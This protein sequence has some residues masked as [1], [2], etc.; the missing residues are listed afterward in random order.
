[1]ITNNL[2]PIQVSD[3]IG[4]NYDWLVLGY[5]YEVLKDGSPISP[6]PQQVVLKISNM[7]QNIEY[8]I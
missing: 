5:L 8:L 2:D 1:M 3:T 7:R 6:A 4:F